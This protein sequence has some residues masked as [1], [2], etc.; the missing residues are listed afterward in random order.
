MGIICLII[1]L[2]VLGS[3]VIGMFVAAS[4]CS[5]RSMI[6][7]FMGSIL[8]VVFVNVG[9]IE[10]IKVNDQFKIMDNLVFTNEY[11]RIINMTNEKGS[12][13]F[14]LETSRGIENIHIDKHN[15]ILEDTN[16]LKYDLE[17]KALNRYMVAIRDIAQPVPD[18]NIEVDNRETFYPIVRVD[19]QDNKYSILYK[20]NNGLK[21]FTANP[22]EIEVEN[23]LDVGAQIRVFEEDVKAIIKDL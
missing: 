4:Y 8:A 2:I 17:L 13:I 23:I 7:C 15:V 12:Y 1:S 11:N 6:C 19:F 22:S 14:E 16:L 9:L 5:P 3:G 21:V 20:T 10:F 18:K